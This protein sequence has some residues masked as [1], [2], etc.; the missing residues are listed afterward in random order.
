M[1]SRQRFASLA[2]LLLAA[3]LGGC[4]E[5]GVSAPVAAD[6]PVASIPQN[7]PAAPDESTA[8]KRHFR[9]GEFGL[10]EAGFQRAVEAAPDNVEAWLGLAAAHNQL[11]RRDL[12]DRDYAQAEKRAG[13][14]VEFLNNRG[15]SWLTRGDFARARKDLEAAARIEPY[16]EFV[17]GN[18]QRLDERAAARR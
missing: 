2:L 4:A 7:S 3:P 11:G 8:A 9:D 15:Y 10:A 17:R 13:R 6:T 16:N 5:L 12:A 14:T 18:I 1:T